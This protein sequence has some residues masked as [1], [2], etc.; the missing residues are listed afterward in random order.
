MNTLDRKLIHDLWRLRG[1]IIAITLIVTCGLA[2]FISMSGTYEALKLTQT[3]YY[4]QL[5]ISS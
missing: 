4:D 1:Q 3:N 2:S 5:G